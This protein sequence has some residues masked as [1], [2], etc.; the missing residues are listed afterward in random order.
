MQAYKINNIILHAKIVADLGGNMEGDFSVVQDLLPLNKLRALRDHADSALEKAL[1][2]QQQ[3]VG[4]DVDLGQLP[5]KGGDLNAHANIREDYRFELSPTELASFVGLDSIRGMYA[6]FKDYAPNFPVTRIVVRRTDLNG[7]KHIQYHSDSDTAVM[8]VWLNEDNDINNVIEG[9][10]LI[11]LNNNSATK[12]ESKSGAATLH[13]NKI[14][15][16]I[17]PLN[18]TRYVLILLSDNKLQDDVMEALVA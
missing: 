1:R 14:V 7:D 10:N 2:I 8:H 3:A 13:K 11:Y 18:G 6:A 5:V 16:G 12:V 17:T 4:V 9:G 15:H